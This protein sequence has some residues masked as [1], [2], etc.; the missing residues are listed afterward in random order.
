MAVTL[1]WCPSKG[2][3]SFR[4][5]RT[6]RFPGQP[7]RQSAVTICQRQSNVRASGV[8][9]DQ[10]GQHLTPCSTSAN[11]DADLNGYFRLK[12]FISG[13]ERLQL[14]PLYGEK[15]TTGLR[16]AV[17]FPLRSLPTAAPCC[18]IRQEV[19]GGELYSL[20]HQAQSVRVWSH[21]I[22]GVESPSFERGNGSN[23]L[24]VFQKVVG[25]RV[26]NNNLNCFNN[27]YFDTICL[28]CARWQWQLNIKMLSNK[29]K[30]VE[31]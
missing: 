27:L 22:A 13:G 15:E 8:K 20:S 25:T 16:S 10:T 1:S 17:S 24:A 9:R 23:L 12:T 31:N 2:L 11:F 19:V 28:C 29:I 14:R 6:I 5:G 3:L 4:K 21:V 26:P 18:Q 30:H 7:S